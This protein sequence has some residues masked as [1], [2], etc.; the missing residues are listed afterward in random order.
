MEFADCNALL[1][2]KIDPQFM[3]ELHHEL[4]AL[5]TR[6]HQRSAGSGTSYFHVRRDKAALTGS[7]TASDDDV[8][9]RL[10]QAD[11]LLARRHR[12]TVEHSALALGD[13]ARDQR[14]VVVDLSAPAF[15]DGPCNLGQLGSERLQF[16]A[17][18]FDCLRPL[19]GQAPAVAPLD[20][21]RS[22]QGLGPAQQ[23]RHDPHRVP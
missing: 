1:S 9:V 2:F 23:A 19:L 16:G 13:D 15:G 18:V 14:Q 3:K 8:S 5:S 6:R 22:R 4:R 12:L 11:Q 21:R 7:A 10:E 20:C 17:A